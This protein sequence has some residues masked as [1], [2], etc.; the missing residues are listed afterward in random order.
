MPVKACCC[1]CRQPAKK[2]REGGE[3]RAEAEQPPLGPPLPREPPPPQ[4]LGCPAPDPPRLLWV[5]GHANQ[6]GVSQMGTEP[7]PLRGQKGRQHWL[8]VLGTVAPETIH[9][10]PCPPQLHPRS[11]PGPSYL[12]GSCPPWGQPSNAHPGSPQPTGPL[13]EPV[14][15][16][17][18]YTPHPRRGQRRGKPTNISSAVLH[19]WGGFCLGRLSPGLASMKVPPPVSRRLNDPSPPNCTVLRGRGDGGGR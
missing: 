7:A 2:E 17:Q 9:R 5:G 12:R 4:N 3:G 8:L 18:D 16:I 13:P 1:Y 11:G 19:V 10:Q 15:W 14:G 6:R